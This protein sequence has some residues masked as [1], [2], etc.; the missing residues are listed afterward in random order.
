MNDNLSDEVYCLN[1]VNITSNVRAPGEYK[2][3]YS[4]ENNSSSD[5]SF[6]TISTMWFTT[7]ISEEL[8]LL[9]SCNTKLYTCNI[10]YC[11]K[12]NMYNIYVYQ[13]KVDY[14]SEN[15]TLKP[16]KLIL[17]D[18][19]YKQRDIISI[20]SNGKKEIQITVKIYFGADN[21]LI[22]NEI[23]RR[24][25]LIDFYTGNF[26]TIFYRQPNSQEP[27]YNIIDTYDEE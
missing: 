22:L 26:V 23:D 8:F 21:Y 18:P 1:P 14:K 7:K 19:S 10:Y 11:P 16:I 3:Y 25:L 27:S 6:L 24:I 13:N 2:Y 17:L 15:I 5:K 9:S 20:D 4:G 12:N